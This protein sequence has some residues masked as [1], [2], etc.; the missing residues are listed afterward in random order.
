[1]TVLHRS[2]DPSP[3]DKPRPPS[4]PH[5]PSAARIQKLRR[6]AR[7]RR[8]I[9]KIL[10]FAPLLLILAVD[11]R[12]RGGR[13][14]DL[15]GK[16]I[17][18]YGAAM[19]ESAV[20]WGALLFAASS[21]RGILRWIASM[22]F[23][24]LAALAVGGQLYF[25]R[26]YS[27]YLNLDA[28]L[29]GTSLSESLFS[30]LRA[31]AK[32]FLASILPPVLLATALVWL[33]R[34]LIRP[35]GTR[36]SRI[37]RYTAPIAVCAALVIPCSYRTVQA[38][39]PDVIYLHAVGG[40]IKELVGVRTTAQVRPGLR[41][42]PQLAPVKPAPLASV[43]GTRAPFRNVLFILTESVRA[44]VVCAEH[45]DTCPGSPAINA[46]VPDRIP[47]LQMR[48]TSSTTAT[49]L[50]VLWSGLSTVA[51][52][53]E[54]HTAP[55]LFD[56]V[57]AAGYDNAY[58]SSHHMM[59]AN[60]R[61]Y[62]QDLPTSHQC[63][64]TDLD[65]LA[66]IDLGG[67]DELLTLRIKRDLAEM[68]EP[69][70]AVAHYGNTHVPYRVDPADSPFQPSLESKAPD[71]NEAYKNYYKNAVYL[72]DRT[73]ADLIR[74]VRSSPAGE[75]TIIVFTSD[76]GEAFREHGQ[77][78]HT[79][80]VLDEEIHVPAWIDAPPGTLGEKEEAALRA[81]RDR[82]V[83][84]TDVA[85]TI[86]DLLGLLDEPSFAPHRYKM[87]GQ[88]LIR[89]GYENLAVPLSNCTGVWGC[90][91]KNWG[92]MRGPM[93]VEAR[94]WDRAWHCYNVLDDPSEQRDLGPS[95]AACSNLVLLADALY[96]GIP[97]G[98]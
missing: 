7:A 70:F 50:A 31:D 48:S 61:L 78:G 58:W 67:N 76:H 15:H 81:L 18:S 94:E 98:R 79:G 52:R 97:A 22:L 29:F 46:A 27:T 41:T 20:L 1:V 3:S 4:S 37:T 36:A 25:H 95:H 6:L 2:V 77:I 88:S 92:V 8:L 35:G 40:L 62:V 91:F 71:D 19:L 33:G 54:L 17:A 44:D 83:F 93:K 74:F 21:R 9:A 47:L 80:A 57:H 12:L 49:E 26:Q 28:T 68:R 11:I 75:R 24:L 30:Q 38:S 85:P 51:T 65:P 13:L 87:V 53:K 84:H 73:I 42:P 63:G 56:Y 14:L 10:L 34:S 66:D 32:N 90:A 5:F 86:L 59:F 23:V 55:L 43:P 64:A 16:H 39:T 89:S 45:R 60:S 72:Q 69:F 82:P 96:G